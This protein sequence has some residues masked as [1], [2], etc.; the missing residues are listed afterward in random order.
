MRLCPRNIALGVAALGL[1]CSLIGLP[2]LG[3]PMVVAGVAFYYFWP[4]RRPRR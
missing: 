3:V 4:R 2:I 1:L